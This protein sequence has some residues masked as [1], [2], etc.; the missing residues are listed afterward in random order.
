MIA[1]PCPLSRNLVKI[2]NECPRNA[3]EWD[4][5][6][7]I[8]NCSSINQT[9]V[10]KDMFVYHCVVNPNQ[11]MFIEV[12][13]P[14]K[15]IYGKSCAEYDSIGSIIQENS[16]KCYG[17]NLTV[18]CPEVYVSTDAFKYQSCYEEVKRKTET[19]SKNETANP[20]SEGNGN[21]ASFIAALFTTNSITIILSV[22]LLF[23]FRRKYKKRLSRKSLSHSTQIP[24]SRVIK[25]NNT[26]NGLLNDTKI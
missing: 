14:L 13:A 2:V 26:K 11:T 18:S 25:Y 9:C 16:N 23:I 15:Y 17:N 24:K 10:Q 6:S 3:V 12:C 5:R 19:A 1:M 22:G 7:A 21:S 8:Y 20:K 4:A